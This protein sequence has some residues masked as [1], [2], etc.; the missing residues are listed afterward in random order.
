MGSL[1]P[2]IIVAQ[3]LSKIYRLY[4]KPQYRMMDMFGLLKN[5]H[6]AYTEHA[7]LD[8]INLQV[9]R[10]EKVAIIGRNGAGKS[11]LLKIITNVIRPTSGT[12]DVDGK[13]HALLQIGTG[14][15]PEFTGR[16]NVYGYLAQ[17]GLTGQEA[18]EKVREV[19]EF[20]E[21]EEYIDQPMKT[22]STGMG[23][24]LMFSTSTAIIP[25]LLV[26]DE[27]LGVGD[28]YFSQKSYERMRDLCEARGTTLL[29][30]THDVYSAM[31]ICNRAIW[32]DRG[33]VL[34]DGDSQTVIKAYEDSIREQEECRLRIK[35]K[36]QLEAENNK[37]PV[38]RF[39]YILFEVMG[40][41]GKPLPGVVYI[42]QISLTFGSHKISL[43]M[44]E[45]A[46]DHDQDG[47]LVSEGSSWGDYLNW[48]ELLVR[49]MLN[50]GSPFHKVSGVF[51]VPEEIEK[52]DCEKFLHLK[53][54][55]EEPCRFHLKIFTKDH[56]WVTEEFPGNPK[57][58]IEH[59]VS[60]KPENGKT[61]VPNINASQEV[62]QGFGRQGSGAI[63]LKEIKVLD[64]ENKETFVL[65]HGKPMSVEMSFSIADPALHENAQ[66]L[67]IFHRDGVHDVCR[68]L[69]RDLIF[70]AAKFKTGIIRMSFPK[71]ILPNGS[72]T[73]S[74][75]VV[76]E[77]YF[78]REQTLFYSI[79]PGAYSVLSRQVEI[80]VKDGE[81]MG[82]GTGLVVEGD[83][84]LI[85]EKEN[86]TAEGVKKMVVSP[87]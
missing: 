4:T 41:D 47:F 55:A 28:A 82:S 34:I 59:S 1:E 39:N 83:W 49:P 66:V 76:E 13:V 69:T 42:N 60:I 74:G 44:G 68:V 58:W 71:L 51:K 56:D 46:F 54:W 24:R 87:L 45:N 37:L 27:V 33:R 2:P 12:I 81:I 30:V 3:N 65:S 64:Q 75:M 31:K 11:T 80:V 14:F 25:N 7:A 40:V 20:A 36:Q 18:D 73:V 8:N 57:E 38:F 23:V 35:K 72:Y 10:G 77:G 17:L 85:E 29:M 6:Q 84:A 52:H 16:E 62:L 9:N 70:E 86:N 22:Y 26:L 15:H 50:Y 43:D 32:I 61:I 5:K 21:L 63:I 53:Y 48:K 78:D 19:I 79:N 67:V